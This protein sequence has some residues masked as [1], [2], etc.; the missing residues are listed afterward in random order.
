[1]TVAP[2]IEAGDRRLDPELSADELERRVRSLTPHVGAYIELSD[3]DRLGVRRA[4]PADNGIAP[5]ELAARDGHLLYGCAGDRALEL[6]EVQPAGGRVMEAG[7]YLRGHG[8]KLGG[9]V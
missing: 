4:Q 2:K 9:G 6:L 3:G 8:A 7:A 5:G 1:V